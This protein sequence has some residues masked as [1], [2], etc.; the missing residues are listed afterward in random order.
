MVKAKWPTVLELQV[1]CDAVLTYDTTASSN[2]TSREGHTSRPFLDSLRQGDPEDDIKKHD[3]FCYRIE[4]PFPAN[5][6]SDRS[7]DYFEEKKKMLQERGWHI[8]DWRPYD[9]DVEIET[10][11]G[12]Q[13]IKK[14]QRVYWGMC[15]VS[16]QKPFH[17]E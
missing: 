3:T 14:K 5:T 15:F 1:M 4:A 17:S 16:K 7:K 8:L 9:A 10:D 12:K 6:D 13:R 2:K 11:F